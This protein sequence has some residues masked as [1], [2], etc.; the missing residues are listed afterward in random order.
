MEPPSR[1]G[2]RFFDS[3][4][5]IKL[6]LLGSTARKANRVHA[7]PHACFANAI[8]WAGKQP[9]VQTIT[10]PRARTLQEVGLKEQI[11]NDYR[12]RGWRFK[13]PLWLLTILAFIITASR[14]GSQNVWNWFWL[15]SFITLTLLGLWLENWLKH[16]YRCPKCGLSL[17]PPSVKESERSQ[18][19]V[20]ICDACQITWRTRTYAPEP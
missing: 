5:K 17:G 14:I 16:T 7:R 1:D 8:C 3:W 13:I 19:Y 9:R 20:Y 12:C 15:T 18:E 4:C 2:G 10:N 11:D 6:S